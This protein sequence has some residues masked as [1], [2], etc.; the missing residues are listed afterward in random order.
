[1]WRMNTIADWV[2]ETE[3]TPSLA[4]SENRTWSKLEGFCFDKHRITVDRP[5]PWWIHKQIVRH[6]H[7]SP[8]GWIIFVL[9]AITAMVNS[10]YQQRIKIGWNNVIICDTAAQRCTQQGVVSHINHWN[11]AKGFWGPKRL[12]KKKTIVTYIYILILDPN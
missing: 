8:Y 12:P 4:H 7:I 11:I 3:S 2:A 10:F 1:M 5:V 9:L 6:W